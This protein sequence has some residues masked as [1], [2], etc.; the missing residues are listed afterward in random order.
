MEIGLPREVENDR[1]VRALLE[2]ERGILWVG[3]GSGLYARE[4]EGRVISV[5][6]AQGLPANDV[7]TLAVMTRQIEGGNPGG[8]GCA[9]CEAV[10]RRDRHGVRR[11][12]GKG[13]PVRFSLAGD[14]GLAIFADGYPQSAPLACGSTTAVDGIQTVTAGASGLSYDAASD[15]YTYVWKTNK[16]WA[17]TCRQLIVRL[18]DGTVHHANFTF[19]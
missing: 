17:Q 7:L 13:I 16:A 6:V 19:R 4:R 10:L 8:D 18:K 3:A 5:T 11:V 9:H 1:I 15:S 12:F 2:D 14:H